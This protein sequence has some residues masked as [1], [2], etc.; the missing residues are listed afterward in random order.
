LKVSAAIV[1]RGARG[2]AEAGGDSPPSEIEADGF[3]QFDTESV[4]N[5]VPL[6]LDP[7][8]GMHFA[9]LSASPRTPREMM[10]A[11]RI[12]KRISDR[13]DADGVAVRES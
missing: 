6:Q 13:H 9:A 4:A 8:D 7:I 12:R 1:S 11:P 5:E 10:F 2:G 3:Q